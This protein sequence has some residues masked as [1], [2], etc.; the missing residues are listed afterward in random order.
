MI[1]GKKIELLSKGLFEKTFMDSKITTRS[2][3]VK[4]KVLGHLIGP[5]GLVLLINTIAA[6]VEIFI[7]K[8]W[9]GLKGAE[10]SSAGTLYANLAMVTRILSTG[11]GLFT[12]WL[13]QHTKSR[14]G[15][16]R[17][18]YLISGFI[19]IASSIGLF[20]IPMP[21][22]TTGYW[23]YFYTLYVVYNVVGLSFYYGFNNNI[24]SL[25]TRDFKDRTSIQFFRKLNWTLIS[26]MVIGMIVSSVLLPFWLEKDID[27][28]W[29]LICVL[30]VI[31]VPLLLLEY[32]YTKERI[33]E[34]V[35]ERDG[36]S[37][38]NSI[39]LREQF[40][41]LFSNK[42]YMLLLVAT[43]IGGIVDNFKGGNVQYFYLRFALDGANNPSLFMLYQIITGVPLGI[44]AAFIYP[45]AKKT[46][47]RNISFFGFFCVAVGSIL[48]LFMPTNL[49]V[50]YI[51]GFI[52][53]L[54][55][56][57]NAY[58]LA[59]L[60]CSAFDSVEHR[61]GYRL[62][63]LLGVSTI[64][65]LQSFIY[66]PFAGRYEE[67]L[68]KAGMNA[69]LLTQSPD[70]IRIL[71]LSFYGFDLILA[72]TWLIILPFINLEKK[73][74]KIN[75]DLLERKKQAILARGEEWIEP[76]ELE[77]REREEQKR[78]HEENRIADLRKRCETR[79]LDFATENSKY[80][81][82]IEAK[83]RKQKAKAKK[84]KCN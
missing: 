62:E 7:Q 44:G 14:Q 31:A 11:M 68:A 65:A 79:G 36:S 34:D 37:H 71:G 81:M 80:L 75:S 67:M 5:L 32:Y 57:P 82:K 61:S 55:M 1:K 4:E 52:R 10:L 18:W 77:L 17:P 25:S 39:Q 29:Q 54:G 41:A 58:I 73:L 3:T 50:A 22:N 46:G 60:I 56:I 8:Q 48:G 59:T 13:M 84:S 38:A 51:A 83:R 6:L 72:V 9:S 23:A 69:N 53:Q 66:A 20:M 64:G 21:S 2:V 30:V 27:A 35:A 15:R 42:Y 63:G 45:L 78:L 12:G 40:K 16:M 43:T 19:A 28:F 26:G 49:T 70:V 24:V 47:I 74:P 33:V 76:E